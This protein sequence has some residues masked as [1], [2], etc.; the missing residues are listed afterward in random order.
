M[1]QVSSKYS[2]FMQCSDYQTDIRAVGRSKNVGGPTVKNC[3]FLLLFW[4][5]G[6]SPLAPLP[7]FPLQTLPALYTVTSRLHGL[8]ALSTCS[9]VDSF[10]NP[11]VFVVIAKL[12]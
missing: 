7:P 9:A 12:R 1:R 5:G 3:L 10:L 11:G 2:F 8:K 4:A 6:M